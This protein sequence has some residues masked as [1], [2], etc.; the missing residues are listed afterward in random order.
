MELRSSTGRTLFVIL[1]LMMYVAFLY[2]DLTDGSSTISSYIKFMVIILCFCYALFA[3]KSADK[4]ILF[5]MKAAL[6][7]TLISD[8]LILILDVYF[9]GVLTFIIVQQ[10]YGVRINLEKSYIQE[11]Y[12]TKMIW[13]NLIQRLLLQMA[14]SSAVCAILVFSG[15]ELEPLLIASILYF[16][17]IVMNT[18]MAVKTALNYRG[19]KRIRTFALGMLLFLLCDINV[20][21][22]NVSGFIN[23]PASMY[24]VINGFSSILMWTFYAPSQVILSL[25][26]RGSMK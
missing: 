11:K 2:L 14:I 16:I 15:M 7:F 8:L 19:Y 1:Q 6:G 21:L 10:I 20:G 12:S 18:F 3:R 13:V 26:T 5:L 17:S 23:I 25:S 9:Y 4:G 24:S 22:F